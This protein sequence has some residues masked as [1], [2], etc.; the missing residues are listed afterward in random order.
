M[1]DL[2]LL[3][4]FFRILLH[5]AETRLIRNSIRL[6]FLI[7][8]S[9]LLVEF[10]CLGLEGAQIL[11]DSGAQ[12]I[13]LSFNISKAFVKLVIF[14]IWCSLVIVEMTSQFLYYILLLSY[15]LLFFFKLLLEHTFEM[16]SLS[17]MKI[18][19]QFTP[20]GVQDFWIIEWFC[21]WWSIFIFCFDCLS[22]QSML[23]E[24]M[25]HSLLL[26]SLTNWL[27]SLLS[28]DMSPTTPVSVERINSM[29][30]GT[31]SSVER[32]SCGLAITRRN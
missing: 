13:T 15:T 2:E 27:V 6:S 12:V 11:C 31:M 19:L 17:F 16:R 4:T 10:V 3:L 21:E 1:L 22:S 28:F 5:S 24:S 8:F 26:I 30:I 23:I 9:D 20:V 29:Q 32:N 14:W 25:N 18:G 7:K